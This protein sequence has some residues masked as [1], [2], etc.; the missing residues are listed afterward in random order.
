MCRS[1]HRG[2]RS[3]QSL[4]AEPRGGRAR[5]C[6]PAASRMDACVSAGR[7]TRPS[8]PVSTSPNMN[9]KPAL[10]DSPLRQVRFILLLLLSQVTFN[11]LV[12]ALCL[13]SFSCVYVT[14]LERVT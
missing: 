3:V 2:R 12:Q 14:T 9:L 11:Q 1:R 4:A 8:T 10:P 6:S 7:S 5:P 13:G